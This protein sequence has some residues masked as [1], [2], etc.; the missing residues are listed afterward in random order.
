M[1]HFAV[2][3]G[4]FTTVFISLTSAS[5]LVPQCGFVRC[6]TQAWYVKTDA[7][8]E[9]RALRAPEGKST[10]KRAKEPR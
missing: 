3:F 9:E 1:H 5:Q 6:T 4:I 8:K 7:W 2:D 10:S